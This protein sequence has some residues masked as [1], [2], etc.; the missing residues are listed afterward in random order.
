MKHIVFAAI[1]FGL[2]APL[3]CIGGAASAATAHNSQAGAYGPTTN[4][5]AHTHRHLK[6]PVATQ[7][8]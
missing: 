8:H 6:K 3:C 7:A 4:V 5:A 2:S 1:V